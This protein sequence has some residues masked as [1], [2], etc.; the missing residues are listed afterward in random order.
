MAYVINNFVRLFLDIQY[1]IGRM[2]NREQK[3]YGTQATMIVWQPKVE[4]YDEFSLGQLWLVSGTY[5]D[6]NINSI[7]AGW[8][9][10]F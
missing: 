2:Y 9:V 6:S 7:E 3:I 10:G 5:E 8:Q 4:T 1:A